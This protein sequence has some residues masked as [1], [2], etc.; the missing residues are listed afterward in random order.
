MSLHFIIYQILVFGMILWD[1]LIALDDLSRVYP[2][3]GFGIAFITIGILETFTVTLNFFNPR[4]VKISQIIFMAIL[5][6]NMAVLTFLNHKS[7]KGKRKNLFKR[8][9]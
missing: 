1:F 7:Y 6:V 8:N 4:D 3:K 9:R 5:N 2:L